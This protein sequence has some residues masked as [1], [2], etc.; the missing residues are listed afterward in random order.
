MVRSV[1]ITGLAFLFAKEMH[2]SLKSPRYGA[3]WFGVLAPNCTVLHPRKL[4][5]TIRGNVQL[6][7]QR[8]VIECPF[9]P[10]FFCFTNRQT[11]STALESS[12]KATIST[13]YPAS[14]LSNLHTDVLLYYIAIQLNGVDV[15][16]GLMNRS[17]YSGKWVWVCSLQQAFHSTC[18]KWHKCHPLWNNLF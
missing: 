17:T 12:C 3:V 14:V 1:A 15:T 11:A 7:Y 2:L 5:I 10:N 9:G 6:R 8:R 13:F 18:R 16:S 4:R